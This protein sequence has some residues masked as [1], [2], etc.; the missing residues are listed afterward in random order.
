MPDKVHP[1]GSPP[2]PKLNKS[3]SRIGTYDEAKESLE[4]GF[5]AWDAEGKLLYVAHLFWLLKEAFWILLMPPVAVACGALSVILAVIVAWR[6]RD[7]G[8]SGKM[9][10]EC[11]SEVLIG[12]TQLC[13]LIFNFIYM[14]TSFIYEDPEKVPVYAESLLESMACT[15]QDCEELG[16]YTALIWTVR[17]GFLLAFTLWFGSCCYLLKKWVE[18]PKFV[19]Q[20]FAF[21]TCLLEG[22]WIAFWVLKDFA[23]TFEAG[24]PIAITFWLVHFVVLCVA[25][26]TNSSGTT[27]WD[28]IDEQEMERISDVLHCGKA[29]DLI[30]SS[31]ICWSISSLLWLLLEEV[32]D[33]D[34]TLRYTSAVVCFLSVVLFL[35]GYS[36]AKQKA[37]A[38]A[39]LFAEFQK[40]QPEDSVVPSS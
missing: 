5:G 39:V 34:L 28:G 10:N 31:Y 16:E 7:G 20:G 1:E 23:W 27:L 19:A 2:N 17:A 6:R 22:G 3:T 30:H 8:A 36:Q 25:M 21:Q 9:Y 14:I 38:L 32:F 29:F 4:S 13:W 11:R 18:P 15:E 33:Y 26:V 24:F 35:R 40:L 12:V 37:Q